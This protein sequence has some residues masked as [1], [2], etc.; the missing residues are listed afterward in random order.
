MHMKTIHRIKAVLQNGEV[1]V[2]GATAC[3][4]RASGAGQ[5][6]A[7]ASQV[8]TDLIP[9]GRFAE[10]ATGNGTRLVEI[11]LFNPRRIHWFA[12]DTGAPV[13]AS[14]MLG[15]AYFTAPDEVGV[16]VDPSGHSLAGRVWVIEATRVG[17]ETAD[18]IGLQGPEGPP[19]P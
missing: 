13:D 8:A 11:E 6:H 16:P 1:A 18:S 4:D 17:I 15:P 14:D 19:G 3:I 5:G 12:N 7:V 10:D 2:E 9:I